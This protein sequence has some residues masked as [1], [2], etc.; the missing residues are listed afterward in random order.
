MS[1]RKTISVSAFINALSGDAALRQI[2]AICKN[3]PTTKQIVEGMVS[4]YRGKGFTTTKDEEIQGWAASKIV[5]LESLNAIVF[6]NGRWSTRDEARV[7]LEK[8]FGT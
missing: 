2:L 4:Y 8:Y 6:N 7:L 1:E 5:L 3:G